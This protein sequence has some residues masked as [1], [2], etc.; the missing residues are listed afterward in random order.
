M[1]PSFA[2]VKHAQ[3]PCCAARHRPPDSHV[4]S[5][6][7]N[8]RSICCRGSLERLRRPSSAVTMY[9]G[10]AKSEVFRSRT[11]MPRSAHASRTPPLQAPPPHLLPRGARHRGPRTAAGRPPASV[12]TK[13]APKVRRGPRWRAPAPSSARC[14][15]PSLRRRARRSG[16][17]CSELRPA[18]QQS[19]RFLRASVACCI[20]LIC[21]GIPTRKRRKGGHGQNHDGREL[22]ADQEQDAEE[23]E[24]A[25]IMAGT[26]LELAVARVSKA[27]ATTRP[28]GGAAG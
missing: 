5:G 6:W 7:V 15:P 16:R 18:G 25:E 13:A 2:P 26:G 10:L 28:L 14:G 9:P 23:G 12:T 4:S 11:F 20:C 22:A 21:A 8:K 17:S 24:A 3:Q 27:T 19:D 1:R